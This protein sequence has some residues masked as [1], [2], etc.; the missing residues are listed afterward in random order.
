MDEQKPPDDPRPEDIDPPFKAEPPADRPIRYFGR[1]TFKHV[2]GAADHTQLLQPGVVIPHGNFDERRD[3]IR[4]MTTL[5]R[6]QFMTARKD[7]RE[8]RPA[9]RPRSKRARRVALRPAGPRVE[10]GTHGRPRALL[11][12]TAEG[13]DEVSHFASAQPLASGFSRQTWS[14]SW[15][16]M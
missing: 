8:E 7:P 16:R 5:E 10:S 14:H 4:R 15:P 12:A 13:R 1:K 9:A 6:Q 3:A 2:P 11:A